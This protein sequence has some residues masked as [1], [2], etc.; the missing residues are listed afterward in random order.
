MS[1]G[2]W[3]IAMKIDFLKGLVRRTKLKVIELKKEY[4]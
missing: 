4:L 1:S 2:F 3:F